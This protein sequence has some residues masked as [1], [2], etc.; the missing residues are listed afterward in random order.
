MYAYKYSVEGSNTA[1]EWNR[2]TGGLIGVKPVIVS[3]WGYEDTD[4][5]SPTWPG[6]QASYGD[7]FTQWMENNHLSNLAW[8]YHHDW[9]PA[10][11][12][13]T[14]VFTISGSFVKGY[15]STANS[16][17]SNYP[18]LIVTNVTINPSIPV[19]NQTFQVSI[20]IKNQ[21]GTGGANDIYRDVYLTSPPSTLI[22]PATGC[23]PQV[24]SSPSIT[25][26]SSPL[27]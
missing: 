12:T 20:A 24:T 6:S 2:D 14:G 3:E 7:P 25:I 26:T 23:P 27:E 8:M 15:I 18:D 5:T 4:V 1:T 13:S 16:G 22:N 21:G 17:G 19:T 11:F 10:F 9:T